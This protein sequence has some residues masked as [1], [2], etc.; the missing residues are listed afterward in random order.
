MVDINITLVI[1]VVNF[2]VLYWLLDLVFFK[3]LLR[4]MDERNNK[5]NSFVEG[6]AKEKAE[7]A[8]LEGDYRKKLSKIHG[9]AALIKREAKDEANAEKTKIL[10]RAEEEASK[11]YAVKVNSLD[12]GLG[13]LEKELQN[14]VPELSAALDNKIYG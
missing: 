1:Q 10:T 4:V 11:M 3:P 13:K 9:E 6:F 8:E 5:M 12:A 14:N 7:L 2:L